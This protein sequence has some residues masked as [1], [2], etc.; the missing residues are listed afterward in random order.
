MREILEQK[1]IEAD[2]QSNGANMRPSALHCWLTRFLYNRRSRFDPLW[3]SVIVGG[4]EEDG[5]TFLGHV[6]HIGT[7]FKENAIATGLGADIAV[8]I[9]R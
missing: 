2:I 8:P 5:S 6:N 9:M 1:Q 7:A 3:T 4:I